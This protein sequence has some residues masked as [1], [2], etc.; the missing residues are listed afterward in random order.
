MNMNWMQSIIYGLVSGVSEILP[1]SSYAHQ[2]LLLQ[3]FGVDSRD[4]VMDLVIHL[5]IFASLFF[6]CRHLIDQLKKNQRPG[7]RKPRTQRDAYA[8]VEVKMIKNATIPM[9]I[10]MVVL[11]YIFG[12]DTTLWAT[13][14]FLVINGIILYLPERM[15]QG[16]KDARMMSG[17]NSWLIGLSGALS[18]IGGF[19]RTGCVISSSVAC[20]ADRQKALNWALL[21]SM[22][23]MAVLSF[24]D[25]FSIIS[26]TGQI[27]FW[28]NFLYYL[29]A[30]IFA[31]ISSNLMVTMI[32]SFLSRISLSGFAYYSWGVALFSFLLYLTAV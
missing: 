13:S 32:R 31:F 25:I 7:N 21:L 11:S 19:S 6:G 26:F 20:G 28:S 1:I 9:V 8:G 4:P 27:H 14:I 2:S 29:L 16:N 22:P 30:G 17:L 5:A 23:A 24:L 15:L 18:V 10:A 12:R 3:L